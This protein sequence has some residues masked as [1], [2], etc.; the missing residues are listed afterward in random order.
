M[1][2]GINKDTGEIFAVKQ[3]EIDSINDDKA[4]RVRSQTL[5]TNV[6]S[7]YNRTTRKSSL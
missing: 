6:S 1:Y 3:I 5:H 7:F 2:L 4:Q